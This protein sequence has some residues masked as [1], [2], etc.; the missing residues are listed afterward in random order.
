MA[1]LLEQFE[2]QQQQSMLV[3]APTSSGFMSTDKAY[4]SSRNVTSAAT[5]VYYFLLNL[6][7]LNL[8][9]YIIVCR[10]VNVCI[11]THNS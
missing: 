11:H 4:T 7:L 8:I 1:T 9:L 10:T 2:Q 6:S 5:Q 3:S